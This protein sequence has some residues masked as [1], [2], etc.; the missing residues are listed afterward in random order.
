MMNLQRVKSLE[1]LT[2]KI[3]GGASDLPATNRWDN[4]RNTNPPNHNFQ[5]VG[6]TTGGLLP[7]QGW[8][9]QFLGNSGTTRVKGGT[10]GYINIDKGN[11]W[12][13]NARAEALKALLIP[14]IS[15]ALKDKIR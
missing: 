7:A 10:S 4:R 8:V 1:D 11:P 3:N 14:Y 13:A 6:Q 5:T 2:I 15:R 9:T 12:L